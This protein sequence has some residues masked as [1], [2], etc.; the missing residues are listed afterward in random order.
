MVQCAW[1]GVVLV[2]AVGS[3]CRCRCGGWGGVCRQSIPDDVIYNDRLSS[4][5]N[6]C[7]G[8]RKGAV[9]LQSL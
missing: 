8:V 1:G 2:V 9:C 4:F 5:R 6:P 7:S 3:L